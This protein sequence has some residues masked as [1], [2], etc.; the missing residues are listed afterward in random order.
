[1]PSQ[2]LLQFTGKS[3]YCSVADAHIDPW[4]PVDKAIITHAHS[5]HARWGSKHYLAHKDS[6]PILR[7]RL[8]QDISLQ[9]VE[10]GEKF[11]INGVTFSLYPAG[12]I[13]GSAQIRVEHKG[14]VWVAS[15]DYKLEDDHFAV[16]Y[17]PVK[18]NVFITES[19]FGLP[20]YKWQPQHE[21]MSEIDTWF[22]QNK[23][24]GKA[25]V[26]MGYSLGKMQR[27]L[28]NIQLPD[29]PIYAHGAIYTLNDR[30][31]QAGFDLPELTLV[32]KETDRKLFRGALVLAPPSVDSSTWIK[33]F[34]P[35]SLGYC[36]GWMA[37]RGAKNRRAVDQ[38]FVLSDHVDW[39]DLNRAVKET[40]AEKVFVTHGYT[41]IFSRWLNENGIEAG[42]V[43]TM[44]G[45][46]DENEEEEVVQDAAVASESY[47]QHKAKLDD[48]IENTS[49]EKSPTGDLGVE[50][51]REL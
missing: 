1:M 35:Y 22:A 9:T 43:H 16:P 44:Y 51:G 15:G 48:E 31:R 7:L 4:I 12:H 6:E 19:T 41:S 18:C 32:T 39:P 40:G 29:E 42:E 3:I 45:N 36:S 25:S 13:I 20:I 21:V 11:V 10:Y 2:P 49:K 37:L 26:L 50:G 33:K 46:E 47:E 17:E 34:N 28:K 38:G 14:E 27:I 23:A 8:G 5:D 24:E 30:L